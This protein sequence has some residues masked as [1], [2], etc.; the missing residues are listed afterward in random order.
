M[1]DH[2]IDTLR[3]DTAQVLAK[4]REERD[5]L[6]LK[7]H[8]ARAEVRDEWQKLEPRF[9]HLVAR[10]GDVAESAGEAS[11]DV[12]TAVGLLGEELRRGYARIRKAMHP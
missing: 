8:L 10:V 5:E 9:E 3:A 12:G 11:R 4:V 7:L 6:R 1:G 2:T